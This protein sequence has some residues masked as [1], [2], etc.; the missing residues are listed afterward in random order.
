MVK[1]CVKQP[2]IDRKNRLHDLICAHQHMRLMYAQHIE[3]HGRRFF[4]EICAR[5][6][7]GI[8]AK[9]KLGV[10]KGDGISWRK[11]KN[12]NYS[13]AEGRHELLTKGKRT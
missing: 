5:D 3:E 1:I 7:E 13:Q 8:M 6:L 2:L 4:E 12:R 10:Y 11:I 9:R